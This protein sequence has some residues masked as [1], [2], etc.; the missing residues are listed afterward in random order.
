V[1]LLEIN[2]VQKT[3]SFFMFHRR[4]KQTKFVFNPQL[5]KRQGTSASDRTERVVV[6]NKKRHLHAVY[7]T[8]Q[9][10][11][12]LWRFQNEGSF[13]TYA[14][15]HTLLLA[16][17]LLLCIQVFQ[18]VAS[19]RN[20]SIVAVGSRFTSIVSNQAVSKLNTFC[21]CAVML[22]IRLFIVILLLKRARK[23]S[24][25]HLKYWAAKQ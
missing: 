15:N 18:L 21:L 16:L 5:S 20:V 13:P 24:V 17:V 9:L 7:K 19:R 11:E 6:Y 2:L 14:P 4:S 22:W 25:A 12:L 23:A 10:S 1:H 3:W 8:I